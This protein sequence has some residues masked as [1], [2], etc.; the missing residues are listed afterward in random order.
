MT[1]SKHHLA[2]PSRRL[3]RQWF[4]AAM[5]ATTLGLASS[6][7]AGTVVWDEAVN[8]DLSNSGTTAT[9]VTFGLGSNVVQGTTGHDV[10]GAID[11][12]YFTFTIG[13]NQILTSLNILAGTQTLGFS[14]IGLQSGT[15]VTLA[16]NTAT[17]AGLLGWTHYDAGDVGTDILDD[18]SVAAN[19]S[20][21]FS[22]PLGPGSYAVWLQEISPGGSVPYGFDFELASVPEASTWAMMLAGFG[23]LGL[24]IRRRRSRACLAQLA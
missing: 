2:Q 11:R 13:P 4:M 3:R 5:A 23:L 22:I 12:D 6:P 19:G 15:Q 10:T 1:T 17:A 8:G 14:F 20:S 18:M 7:A 9:A 21:G 16:T 24:A